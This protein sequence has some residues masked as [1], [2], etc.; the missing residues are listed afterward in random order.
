MLA[1]VQ[2]QAEEAEVVWCREQDSSRMQQRLLQDQL[3]AGRAPLLLEA[4][5][6]CSFRIISTLLG[7]PNY[8]LLLPLFI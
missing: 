6:L 2:D 3:S 8:N 1:R 5:S 4:K 7:L